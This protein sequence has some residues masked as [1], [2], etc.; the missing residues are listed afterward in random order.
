MVWHVIHQHKDITLYVFYA[1]VQHK[2]QQRLDP[3]SNKDSDK[4]QFGRKNIPAPK[5][6]L[7]S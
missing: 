2:C 6:G 5:V 4:L 7:S 3:Y 1:H